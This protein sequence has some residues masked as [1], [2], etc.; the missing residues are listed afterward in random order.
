[1][2]II[3]RRMALAA[4]ITLFGGASLAADFPQKPVRLVVAFAAGSVPDNMARAYAVKLKEIWQQPIV[5]EAKPG[6]TGALAAEALSRAP[7]DGYHLMLNSNALLINPWMN[8]QRFDVFKDLAP[9]IRTAQTPYIFLTS[10]KL[11]VKNFQEF[12][13]FAKKHPG[14]ISCSTY[15]VASPPHLALEMLNQAAGIK[16]THVPYNTMVAYPDLSSGT[17]DCSIVP[18]SGTVVQYVQGGSMRA[19]A[20]SDDRPHADY[21]DAEPV[22]KRYPSAK[23]I[24]WQ[25]IFAPASIAPP[26]L[27]QIRADWVSALKD[28]LV[29]R[30]IKESGFEPIADTPEAFMQAMKQEYQAYGDILRALDV[31]DR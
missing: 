25:A 29:I 9:V 6:A 23:V 21:P 17:L 10:A 1:M 26:L 28:P 22:A 24:G 2:K 19:I 12:V 8:K 13:A 30:R 3:H 11:P 27:V 31:K 20:V 14:K 5:I 4:S 18:P 15:G 7:G 16:I